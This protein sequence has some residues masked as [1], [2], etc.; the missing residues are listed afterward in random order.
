LGWKGGAEKA[1]EERMDSRRIRHAPKFFWSIFA[2]EEYPEIILLLLMKKDGSDKT[3]QSY[4]SHFIYKLFF[5]H[6]VR[7]GGATDERNVAIVHK[8][9]VNVVFH[10][11]PH[12]V[13]LA[14]A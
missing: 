12:D 1:G 8:H 5:N 10:L 4:R 11:N 13:S 7:S 6:F 9:F 14:G 2:L 3:E